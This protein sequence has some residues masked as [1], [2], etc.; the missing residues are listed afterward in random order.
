MVVIAE[1]RDICNTTTGVV[2]VDTTVIII[3]GCPPIVTNGIG[4]KIFI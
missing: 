3:T 2:I 1:K 4:C